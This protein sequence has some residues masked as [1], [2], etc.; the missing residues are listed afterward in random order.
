MYQPLN[1]IS[2]HGVFVNFTMSYA[3]DIC[4]ASLL[5]IAVGFGVMWKTGTYSYTP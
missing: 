5:L 2:L 4:H 1:I 3:R